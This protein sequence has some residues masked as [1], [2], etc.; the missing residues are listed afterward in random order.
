MHASPLPLKKKKASRSYNSA[1]TLYFYA[2]CIAKTNFLFLV[3]SCGSVND[4]TLF[5]CASA[6]LIP[7][8]PRKYTF[9]WQQIFVVA[10]IISWFFQCVIFS[11]LIGVGILFILSVL[12][13]LCTPIFY[14]WILVI[15]LRFIFREALLSSNVVTYY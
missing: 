14:S 7:N 10:L 5:W 1:F 3:W 4:V 12:V 11:L 8:K 15:I 2:E 13:S 6:W 9:W